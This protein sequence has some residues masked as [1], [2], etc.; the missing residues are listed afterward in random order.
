M[1]VALPNAMIGKYYRPSRLTS[2]SRIDNEVLD[3]L[4]SKAAG[5]PDQIEGKTRPD[6]GGIISGPPGRR[7]DTSN[8]SYQRACFAPIASAMIAV[9]RLLMLTPSFS[10]CFVNLE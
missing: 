8:R 3:W 9:T 2:R 1:T 4:K 7:F 6:W 10:A 5:P